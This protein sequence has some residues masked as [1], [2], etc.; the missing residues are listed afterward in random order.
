MA[1]IK[2]YK[3]DFLTEDVI[4]TDIPWLWPEMLD[5]NVSIRWGSSWGWTKMLIF[6]RLASVWLWLQTF[7]WFW[8]TPKWYRILMARNEL[9]VNDAPCYSDWWYDWITKSYLQIADHYSRV[10]TWSR[11]ARLLYTNQWGGQTAADHD[12]F[13]SDWIILDF[14]TSDENCTIFITA[15]A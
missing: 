15:Y 12:S 6:E 14:E 3:P 5:S 7:S 1:K 13:T 2:E 8:F 11:V 10:T 9:T 4:E